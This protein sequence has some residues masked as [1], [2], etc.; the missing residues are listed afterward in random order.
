MKDECILVLNEQHGKEVINCYKASGFDTG[1]HQGD[2]PGFYYGVKS[3]EFRCNNLPWGI[4][5]KFPTPGISEEQLLYEFT[6]EEIAIELGVPLK[7][8]RIKY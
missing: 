1:N 4:E 3:G 6:L 2:A 8:L 7:Q 5:I